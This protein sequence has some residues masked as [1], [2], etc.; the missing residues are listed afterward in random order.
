MKKGINKSTINKALNVIYKNGCIANPIFLLGMP[1]ETKND[2]KQNIAFIKNIAQ[3]KNTII[4]MSFATP[5]PGLELSKSG[6]DLIIL[7]KD[8]SR[9]THKQPVAVPK[10]L[11]RNGLK[12]LINTYHQLS[13]ELGL[14]E[15]N[16]RIDPNY[17]K[18]IM[19]HDGHSVWRLENSNKRKRKQMEIEIKAKCEEINKIREALLDLGALS[20]GTIH[21]IDEYYAHDSLNIGKNNTIL[22]IRY[23]RNNNE[24][25]ILAYH[26]NL[27]DGLNNEYELIVNDVNTL[28]EILV[29]LKFYLAGTIEKVRE[30]Y[31]YKEFMICLD[32]IKDIGDFIEIEVGGLESEAHEKRDNCISLLE[33]LGV[34][35]DSICNNLWL[36]DIALNNIRNN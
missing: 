2:L 11:G 28:K 21:Q 6:S 18:L 19:G 13:E 27:G 17:L 25:G 1:G 16:P 7:S 22:R 30:T 10:S 14:T 36:S 26:I 29:H 31:N 4:Y 33:M 15:V 23:Q 9:Y 8:Y 32:N 34:S 35:K 12:L 5:H 24:Y 20:K 3:K